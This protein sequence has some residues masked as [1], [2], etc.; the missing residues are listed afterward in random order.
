MEILRQGVLGSV[1]KAQHLRLNRTVALRLFALQEALD[2]HPLARL[3]AEVETAARLHH[4]NI[5]QVY[6]F[7]EYQ[8]LAYI[9][10]EFIEGRSLAD[11]LA[12]P[13]KSA[14]ETAALVETFARA[15]HHAH[16]QQVVHGSMKPSKVRLGIVGTTKITLFSFDKLLRIPRPFS[17]GIP[18]EQGRGMPS[19]D[20]QQALVG[21]SSYSAPEQ[22]AEPGAALTPAIDVYALGA[23]LYELLAGRPL[24]TEGVSEMLVRVGKPEPPRHWRPEVPLGLE[25]ICLKCLEREPSE[26]YPSAA[27]LAEDLRRF[28]GGEVLFIDNLDDYGEQERWAR[29][30][31]YE[32]L[33]VL[34]SDADGFSYKARQVA[35]NRIV[36]LKRIAAEHRFVPATKSR[37]RREAYSLDG[38]R[39]PNFVQLF[40]LGEQNDLTY[41]AR[42]FVDGPSLAEKVAEEPFPPRFAAELVE[43][44]AEAIDAAHARG[45][46]HGGL[47]PGK[48]RLAPTSVPKI[49]TFRRAWLP[50]SVSDESPQGSQIRRAAVYLAPEQ[51]ERGKRL[52][53]AMDIYALG[54]ILY[55]L[56]TGHPPF[57]APTLTETLEQV[58]SQAPASPSQRQPSV[59]SDLEAICLQCLEKQPARRPA[60]AE[61]LAEEL[62]T[63]LE[64]WSA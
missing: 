45:A 58:R 39:H 59:P 47:T 11:E 50:A 4:P 26:R 40:D 7:G 29:R 53:P 32:I 12:G 36:V 2:A 10:E 38:L 23:I 31:G 18:G 6:D 20:L 15:L 24:V 52:H 35:I 14:G 41:F 64:E 51:L 37:F 34:G 25:A 13:L 1:Y 5:V 60:S 17:P 42:E 55:T 28:R 21:L 46:V 8:G 27:A 61:A 62:R 19:T 16:L 44:L 22:L 3:R 49:T 9:A 33:E 54:A 30:A 63:W 56:L 48:V 43:A 57:S